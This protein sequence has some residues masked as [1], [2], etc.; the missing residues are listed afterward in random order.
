MTAAGPGRHPTRAGTRRKGHETHAVRRRIARR[1]FCCCARMGRH[2]DTACDCSGRTGRDVEAAARP[3]SRGVQEG[4]GREPP[5]RRRR[6]GRA[7]GQAGA[8]ER[9]RLPGQGCRQADGARFRVPHLLDDQ[10]AGLR[11]HDDPGR[12]RQGAAHRSGV[13]VHPGLQGPARQRRQGRRRIRARH[14]RHGAGRP[15]NDGAGPAAPHRGP[16]LWRNHRERTRERRLHQGR[17]LLAD[18]AR[19]RFPRAHARGVQRKARRRSA[20][21]SAGHVLG[22][23][24]RERPARS[25]D[26]SRLRAAPRRVPR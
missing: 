1:R 18:G 3:Y 8:H 23:Q 15:R 12:G 7:Q 17:P 16:C 26:R 10:A 20:R 14:L 22:V 11:R 2:E 13:E 25:G 19:L 9:G 6:H 5:A 4:G 21:A 24:P